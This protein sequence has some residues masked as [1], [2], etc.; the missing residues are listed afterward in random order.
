MDKF[1]K[2][3]EEIAKESREVVV[4]AHT[5]L[6][7]HFIDSQQNLYHHN[8]IVGKIIS[9]HILMYKGSKCIL[10][11]DGRLIEPN[12]RPNTTEV[13]RFVLEARSSPPPSEKRS[14][15][16]DCNPLKTNGNLKWNYRV[17][18]LNANY[19]THKYIHK[20]TLVK[21]LRNGYHQYLVSYDPAI[22]K[23]INIKILDDDGTS[24]GS[25]L[26]AATGF[27]SFCGFKS[28]PSAQEQCRRFLA[29]LA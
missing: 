10:R 9:D 19:H 13:V 22:Y 29:L 1:I 7:D 18:S 12:Y 15:I 17:V 28:L 14:M 23:N 8:R 21:K 25:I 24:I 16:L 4:E 3:C 2:L 6:K 20:D 5:L 26:V 27:L 11:N